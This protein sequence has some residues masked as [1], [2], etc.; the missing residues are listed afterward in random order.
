MTQ[1]N[2]NFKVITLIGVVVVLLFFITIRGLNKSS[3]KIS[4]NNSKTESEIDVYDFL[5][6]SSQNDSLIGL[7]LEK[8]KNDSTNS[9]FI[10][11][12]LQTSKQKN[13]ET[14]N[15]FALYLKGKAENNIE[16][17]QQSADKYLDLSSQDSNIVSLKL[18]SNYGKKACDL[19]LKIQPKNKQALTRKASFLIYIDNETMGGVQLLK[20]VEKI[21]SNYVEAQHLL[22]ILAIQSQ[23]FEKAEKRLKKLIS[24]QPENSF[25]KEL[26]NKIET[27]QLK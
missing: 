25:Y 26:L 20:D 2:N 15:A 8:L 12:L 4:K 17:L 16:I 6:N 7:L 22:M 23:Q 21:D 1:Y 14:V 10:D 5:N 11:K 9:E 24:L 27:Q 18:Y 13:L 19:I 3:A